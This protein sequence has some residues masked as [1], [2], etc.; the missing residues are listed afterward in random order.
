MWG[1][2]PK[3]PELGFLSMAGGRLALSLHVFQGVLEWLTL[4]LGVLVGLLTLVR[5]LIEL[6]VIS[7]PHPRRRK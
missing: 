4:I 5:L 3:R 6:G 1:R 7:K 2:Y